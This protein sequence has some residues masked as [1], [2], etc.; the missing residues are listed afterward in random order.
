MLKPVAFIAVSSLDFSSRPKVM[1]T[2]SSTPI[3]AIR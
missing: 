2:A 3:G 1:S